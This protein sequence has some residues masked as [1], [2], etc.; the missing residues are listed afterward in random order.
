MTERLKPSDT[1][2][3]PDFD[4]ERPKGT[5]S[6]PERPTMLI[7]K[8]A[9][10]DRIHSAM[11]ALNVSPG[12][13]PRANLAGGTPAYI[14]EFSDR[15]GEEVDEIRRAI[16]EPTPAQMS[17][18]LPA[19]RLMEGL[20]RPF[21]KVVMLRALN[22][23][24]IDKGETEPFPWDVIGEECGGLSGKW[25]EDAYDAAMVQAARR[26][27]ILPMVSPD[28]GILA[29]AVWV[30]RGWLTNLS[31]AS[32]PR[33]AISNLKAK[34]PI[35]P[36]QAFTLWVAG[37]YE[38]KRVVEAVRPQLRGLHSHGAWF[39]VHP[40]VLAEQLIDTARQ[41]GANWTFED[42]AVRGVMAA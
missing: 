29:V 15:V 32:E 38:A 19:L 36:E 3:K 11:L 5:L 41:L 31:T 4:G 7:A 22:E 21:F 24:A 9:L 13:G 12:V 8:R 35:R 28:Y 10:V 37:Q 17:D 14:V 30:D 26:A 16:Y 25:A 42:V 34:S 27:G 2:F 40:D 20:H 23:F 18:V 33:A 1:M 6:A 39:K